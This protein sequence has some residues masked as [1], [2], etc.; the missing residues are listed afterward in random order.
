M[1]MKTKVY[2]LSYDLGVGGDYQHLYQWLDDK[3]AKP[4]GNSVAFFYFQYKSSEPDK[5][6]LEE[7]KQTVN[8]EPGNVLYVVRKKEDDEKYYGSFLYG[9]RKS[10]PWVG[11]GTKTSEVEDK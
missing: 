2:W 9:K 6:L 3:D 1:I 8:L 10:A 11:Y 5:E 4:C 7:I